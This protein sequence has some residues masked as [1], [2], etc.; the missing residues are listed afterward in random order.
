MSLYW[1]KCDIC[2]GMGEL[3]I[4]NR[5]IKLF[6]LKPKLSKCPICQGKGSIPV[7]KFPIN[8]WR[9]SIDE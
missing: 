7:K 2:N 6:Q 3:E 1:K 5:F 9:K 8:P 4:T